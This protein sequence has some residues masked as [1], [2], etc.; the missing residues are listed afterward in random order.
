LQILDA[1]F[2]EYNQLWAEGRRWLWWLG[3]NSN[4]PR[5]ELA[6]KMD[7]IFLRHQLQLDRQ[8]D[9]FECHLRYHHRHI[10]LAQ[11]GI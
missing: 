9:L 10:C 11:R 4:S 1:L 2:P 6:S 8:H 7:K 5:V 3:L